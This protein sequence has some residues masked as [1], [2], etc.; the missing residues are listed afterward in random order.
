MRGRLQYF[1]FEFLLWARPVNISDIATV[2]SN[3]GFSGSDLIIAVAV[4]MAESSGNPQSLGDLG[5]G[6]GSFGLWQISSKYH[7]EYGPD[8]S[9]LYDPQ[10][11][12]NAAY[13][14]YAAAGNSFQPWSTFKS[15]IYAS[16]V[17]DASSA[18]SAIAGAVADNPV[19]SAGGLL[20]V[21]ALAF[22]LLRKR[23]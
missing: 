17:E 8:F 16:F 11:N 6:Q 21:V 5:I 20:L 2:A 23:G 13:Q 1:L 18:V 10:T 19:T 3:A 15:G 7:P 22:L 12:A 14:I 9:A 4:A